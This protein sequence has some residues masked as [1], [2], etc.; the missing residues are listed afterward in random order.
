MGGGESTLVDDLIQ[1]E[2]QNITV[3]DIAQ[4]ALEATWKRLGPEG[5]QVRWIPGDVTQ[6]FLPPRSFD[7]WHDRAVFHFLTAIED[8]GAYVR[9]VLRAM[10]PGGFV[11]VSTFG[12]DGPTRCSGLDVVRYNAAALHRQFGGGFRLIESTKEVHYTPWGTLHRGRDVSSAPNYYRGQREGG[13]V[14]L[15]INNEDRAPGQRVRSGKGPRT[16]FE[17]FA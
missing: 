17:F 14:N 9:N 12:P 4:T 16:F 7:I 10:R 15:L 3:L 5:E 2:F 11:I 13:P 8:R 1:R 6:I